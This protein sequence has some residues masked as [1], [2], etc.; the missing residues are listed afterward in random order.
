MK[1][2]LALL[3][4][5]MA[6]QGF[7]AQVGHAEFKAKLLQ[8]SEKSYTVLVGRKHPK[9]DKRWIKDKNVNVGDI[10]VVQ[11]LGTKAGN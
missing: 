4:T 5:T 2:V 11:L 7:S 8:K 10:V 1:Y 9:V 6:F 3:L